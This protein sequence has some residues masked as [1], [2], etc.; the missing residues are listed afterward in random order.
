M[1]GSLDTRSLIW[2]MSAGIVTVSDFAVQFR[3]LAEPFLVIE[4]IALYLRRLV[5]GVFSADEITEALSTLARE[6][7]IRDPD[8][9]TLGQYSRFLERP[10]H[11]EKLGLR[12]DQKTFVKRLKCVTGIRNDV[13]HFNTKGLPDNLLV[14]LRNFAGLF[15]DLERVSNK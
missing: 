13:M 9:L 10:E 2:G 7:P 3:R 4:E 6:E 11:W 5:D 15:R 1:A 12:L 14:K 8:K